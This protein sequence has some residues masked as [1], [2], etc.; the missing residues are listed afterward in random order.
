MPATTLVVPCYN[1][2]ERLD[3]E[4]ILEFADRCPEIGFL[5]VDDGSRD[6]TWEVL[7]RLRDSRPG[8]IEACRLERNAG[9]A[10][11][12]RAGILAALDRSPR[13]VGYWDAD[14][15]T[16][17]SEAI[18]LIGV[19]DDDEGVA[20][21]IGSRVRMLGR[22][23]Q[24]RPTR[25]LAGRIFATLTSLVLGMNVY[26]TQCGAKLFRSS[27]AVRQVFLK[28]FLSPWAF[29]VE[30]LA[31]LMTSGNPTVVEY[32]LREWRHVSGSKIRVV[33]CIRI[34]MDLLRIYCRYSC[35]S[36]E[37]RS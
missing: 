27:A 2:A 14:L 23:I 20:G 22:S 37:R 25:H 12:V 1:E 17:L 15:A 8:A 32:P 28:P 16:P 34:P 33:D 29:D 24:R 35:C 5:F 10:E 36:A 13:Y 7:T 31:R 18:Q 19:L 3:V 30:I 26:D 21:V 4:A 11:A 9:K 6:A